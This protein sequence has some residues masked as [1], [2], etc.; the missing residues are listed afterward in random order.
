MRPY[1]PAKVRTRTAPLFFADPLFT[2]SLLTRAGKSAQPMRFVT[3]VIFKGATDSHS[4][5]DGSSG[6]VALGVVSRGRDLTPQPLRRT[7]FEGGAH[8]YAQIIG[9]VIGAIAAGRQW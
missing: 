6:A 8:S 5:I 3:H 1:F 2:F 4:P 7:Q 9:S